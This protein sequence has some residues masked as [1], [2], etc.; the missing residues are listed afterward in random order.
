MSYSA[1]APLSNRNSQENISGW[2][3]GPR[4][5]D[6]QRVVLGVLT[7]NDQ[8]VTATQVNLW[9]LSPALA[10]IS[11]MKF[12]KCFYLFFFKRVFQ[13]NVDQHCIMCLAMGSVRPTSPV[14]HWWLN[15]YEHPKLLENNQL[16]HLF[17]LQIF[18]S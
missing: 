7:E 4:V 1:L 3:D 14:Q 2:M 9:I 17:F 10:L 12:S 5:K 11:R 6:G 13:L 8:N 15:Q 18:K 16:L